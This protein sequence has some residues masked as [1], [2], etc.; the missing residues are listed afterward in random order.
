MAGWTISL[1]F[2]MVAVS[3]APDYAQAYNLSI[4]SGRP[5]VVLVGADW[6]PG[7]ATMKHSTMTKLRNDG[8]L[9]DVVYTIVDKDTNPKLAEKLM[10]G[11]SIPQLLVYSKSKRG[12]E[13]QHFVG[14]QS[15]ARIR[16]AINTAVEASQVEVR[17]L[18][19]PL[20]D[21]E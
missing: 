1:L 13:K 18:R 6:C 19:P 12:W 4:G 3:G 21:V 8:A 14:V 17:L 2:P 11:G 9:K 10:R 5:L 16:S 20:E 15:G 7:C